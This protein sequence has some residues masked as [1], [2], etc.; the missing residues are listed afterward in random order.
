[1]QSLGR[2]KPG[3]RDEGW[4]Q[5]QITT[6]RQQFPTGKPMQGL[7]TRRKSGTLGFSAFCPLLDEAQLTHRFLPRPGIASSF[8]VEAQGRI[9]EL[10]VQGRHRRLRVACNTIQLSDHPA[11]V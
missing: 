11:A 1:M 4:K 2:Y 7:V 6:F 3:R 9:A 8:V 10:A 5:E